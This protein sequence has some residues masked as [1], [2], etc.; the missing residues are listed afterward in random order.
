MK[1]IS[2]QGRN[3]I[4]LSFI[5]A[6]ILSMLPLPQILQ[7]VRPEFILIV[8]IYWCI[9]IP[10]RIGVGIG[11]FVGLLYD[12]SSDALLGQHA[13]TYALIAYLAIKLHLR[14]R[15]FPLWQQALTVFVFIM[16]QG[17]IN[18]WVRGMLGYS[19]PLYEL[20]L[21]AI[22]SAIFWPLGYILLRQLRRAYQIN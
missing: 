11:W 3:V 5:L 13:L 8:L 17:T 10:S 18:L 21:P 9:A 1:K 19:I 2:P 22:S 12:V 14:I 15:V 6:F 4:L 7:T 16:V 20:S